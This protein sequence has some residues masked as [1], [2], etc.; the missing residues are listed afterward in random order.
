MLE[1][2]VPFAPV[3]QSVS[4][5]SL[6]SQLIAV[7]V[8]ILQRTLRHNR[9]KTNRPILDRYDFIVV[10]SGTA[11]SILAGRL[12]E[13]PDWNVLVL[14]AGGPQTITTDTPSFARQEVSSEVDWGYRTISQLPNAGL[15]FDG[16]VAIP[17]GKVVGGSHNLNYLVYSRGNRKD[18]DTWSQKFG[19]TGW[20]YKEVLPYFLRSEN[21]TDVKIVAAD[22]D[23]HSITGNV[24]IYTPHSPDGIITLFKDTLI[25]RGVPLI[26]QNG[27]SQ[28]GINYFQQTIFPENSTR[29]TTASVFLEPNINRRNLQVLT[30]AFVTKILFNRT[31]DGLLVAIGVEYHHQNQTSRVYADREV[32]LSAGSI[33]SPQLLML[34]GIGPRAHLQQFGLETLIDLPVGFNLKDHILVPLDY[35]ILNSSLVTSGIDWTLDNMYRNFIN[36]S[37][38]L[39]LFPLVYMYFNSRLNSE[40]DWPDLQIDFNVNPLSSNLESLVQ[41]Y[42]ERYRDKWRQYY[43]PYLEKRQR[44]NVLCFHYRPRSSGRLTLRSS[45]PYD[46]P[47]ID[48]RY[49]TDSYDIESMIEVIATG[50]EI[51]EMEPLRQYVRLYRQPIPGCELCPDEPNLAKCRSYLECYA[52]TLT[53]TVGHQVGTCRMGFNR[54]DS[55]VNPR[56]LVHGT[57]NLRVIDGSIFPIITNGNTNAPIMMIAERAIDLIK[58]DHHF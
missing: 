7:A 57:K 19:A 30:D 43:R 50:L 24:P 48:T 49:L 9:I 55:V 8:V 34:S 5:P 35:E 14:E 26:D 6:T 22:P 52:R 58:D 36:G 15:A 51:A 29:A 11:G 2:I 18:F 45:N 28:I 44:L 32:L 13:N 3:I 23:Y 25:A 17:R 20:S 1:N 21:N 33:N 47:I 56:L 53:T 4:P 39:S 40:L 16:H 10:G 38:P 46:H 27:P 41:P 54:N 37:G 31:D 42:S 12:T